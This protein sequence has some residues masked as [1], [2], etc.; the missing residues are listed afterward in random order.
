MRLAAWVALVGFWKGSAGGA[1]WMD[2][3][4]PLR[5]PLLPG[6]GPVGSWGIPRAVAAGGRLLH[7]NQRSPL[8]HM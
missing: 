5:F 8:E 4:R 6:G 7:A 1:G 2:A 3:F